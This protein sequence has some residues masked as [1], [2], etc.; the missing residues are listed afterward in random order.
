MKQPKTDII[1]KNEKFI[2]IVEE[3]GN[4]L[5]TL[6]EVNAKNY[7]AKRT[8]VLETKSLVE[9]RAKLNMELIRQNIIRLET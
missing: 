6:L 7:V 9:A 2:G 5:V 3:E 8:V 4:F 1:L